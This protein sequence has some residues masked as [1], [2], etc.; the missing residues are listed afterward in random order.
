MAGEGV[1]SCLWGSADEPRFRTAYEIARRI[2][3]EPEGRLAEL[4]SAC[5]CVGGSMT[6][7]NP[8]LALPSRGGG[9][10]ADQEF[11]SP[12]PHEAEI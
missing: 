4:A 5:R 8:V 6:K 12:R 11:W 7:K 1:G 2:P 9:L 10:Q 3:N